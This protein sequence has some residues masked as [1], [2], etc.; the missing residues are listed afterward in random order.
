MSENRFVRRS[1]GSASDAYASYRLAG[2]LF[3]RLEDA[4]GFGQL[5]MYKDATV[6]VFRWGFTAKGKSY[7][8]Q[9]F[10]DS[11]E[12]LMVLNRAEE[13]ARKWKDEHRHG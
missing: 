4:L 13:I 3:G 2:E 8:S 10:V 6:F 9:L 12:M 1:T 7:G 5:V 11:E